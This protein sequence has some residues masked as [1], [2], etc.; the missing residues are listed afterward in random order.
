MK[1]KRVG[2]RRAEGGAQGPPWWPQAPGR[3]DDTVPLER[4]AL[5]VKVANS[6]KQYRARRE[7]GGDGSHATDTKA[8]GV[9]AGKPPGWRR[10]QPTPR[11]AV[12]CNTPRM[13]AEWMLHV[14]HHPDRERWAGADRPTSRGQLRVELVTGQQCR[15]RG[16]MR[17]SLANGRAAEARCL[18]GHISADSGLARPNK[19]ERSP[20]H[21]APGAGGCRTLSRRRV[22]SVARTTVGREEG[23]RATI[24]LPSW[25]SPTRSSNDTSAIRGCVAAGQASKGGGGVLAVADSPLSALTYKRPYVYQQ[26]AWRNP[27]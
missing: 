10:L 17:S 23:S 11:G 1:K 2:G 5:R 19:E 12:P 4:V 14:V 22:P 27:F 25:T 15:T 18:S 13:S 24:G 6:G 9:T 7:T 3:R 20:G 16:S 8:M 26:R 21:G